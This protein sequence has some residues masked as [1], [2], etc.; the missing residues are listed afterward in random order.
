MI[1]S[2][3]KYTKY[4]ILAFKLHTLQNLCYI[5]LTTMMEDI[6]QTPQLKGNLSIKY[7]L[8]FRPK[9]QILHIFFT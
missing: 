6:A 7:Y 8:I 2:C 9:F 5:A 1:P 3:F 4:I